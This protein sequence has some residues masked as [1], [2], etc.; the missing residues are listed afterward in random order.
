MVGKTIFRGVFRLPGT[1]IFACLE[2]IDAGS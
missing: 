1:G 2:M